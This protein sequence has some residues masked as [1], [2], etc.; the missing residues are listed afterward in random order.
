MKAMGPEASLLSA[1]IDPRVQ[2]AE[3]ARWEYPREEVR[4]VEE[5]FLGDLLGPEAERSAVRVILGRAA[6]GLGRDRRTTPMVPEVAPLTPAATE[7]RVGVPELGSAPLL[8]MPALW[9]DG[10]ERDSGLPISAL[11]VVAAVRHR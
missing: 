10:N 4:A 11:P 6:G 9:A 1:K 3:Y 7:G 8:A 5:R 2:L